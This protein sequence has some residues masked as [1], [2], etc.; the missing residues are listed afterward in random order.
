MIE[1]FYAKAEK[2]FY[3]GKNKNDL[4]TDSIDLA[5]IEWNEN[6]DGLSKKVLIEIKNIIF[7]L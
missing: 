5:T 4:N 6:C 7:K 1:T 3:T 2:Y